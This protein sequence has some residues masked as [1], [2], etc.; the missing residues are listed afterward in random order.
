VHAPKSGAQVRIESIKSAYW[1]KRF[2]GAR[3][4][5]PPL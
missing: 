1:A 2:D 4:I 5:E 3:R